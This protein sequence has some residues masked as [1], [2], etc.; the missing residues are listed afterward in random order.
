MNI[1][2]VNR[3]LRLLGITRNFRAYPIL[4]DCLA[5]VHDDP[6]SLEAVTKEVY[7]PVAESYIGISWKGV[8]SA[9]RR[10]VNLAWEQK[11]DFLQELAGHPLKK[12]PTAA[13]FL[14][15][16]YRATEE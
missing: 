7:M 6:S 3:I 12:R 2:K 1:V 15:L 13:H 9:I 8:Q 5:R 16:L 11:P 4:V 10:A 14:E